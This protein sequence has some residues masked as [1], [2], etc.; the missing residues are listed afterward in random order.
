VLFLGLDLGAVSIKA[1]LLG[2]NGDADRVARL[3]GSAAVWHPQGLRFELAGQPAG[4][5]VSSYRRVKGRPLDAARDL[6]TSVFRSLPEGVVGGIRVTGSGGNLVSSALDFPEENEFRALAAATSAVAPDARTLFEIGGESSKMLLFEPDPASGDLAIVDY[7]TNGDCAAGT[8]SFLDQQAGRLRYDIEDVG[9][10]AGESERGAKIAGRCSVFAKSDMIHAQQKGYLPPEVLRGLC[11][12]V[13]RNF[14]AAVTK[15]KKPHPPVL[16]VGGVAANEMVASGLRQVFE[17]GEDLLRVPTHHAAHAAIGCAIREAVTDDHRPFSLADLQRIAPESAAIPRSRRLSMSKVVSLRDRLRPFVLPENGHPVEVTLGIDIGS[18]STNV[19]LLDSEGRVVRE[20]YTR[21]QARP[22]EVVTAALAELRDEVGDR[23]VVRAAGTTG[24]G[25]ELIGE[26]VGADTI[27]DEITAHKTGATF[28]A[29]TMLDGEVNTIFE[30]GGQDSKFIRI[31]DGVVV[32]FA[33]NEA[34][35]A[36]TGSFLEERAEELGVCIKGEFA[37]RALASAT[38]VRLGER[39]TVFM[40][41]DVNAYQQRGAPTDDLLAGLALSVATNYINRVVRDRKIDG[42]IFFQGGTAYNDAVAAAFAEILDRE[43]IVPP[44][45][46]VVGAVGAA[47][48]AW[49][50]ARTHD[51][52]TRFRGWDLGQVD[53]RI[54][55]FTCQGCENRCDMQ[56]FRVEGEKTYWGDQCG[57]RYRRRSK[58]EQRPV[59]DDLVKQRREWLV[60][61]HE[62]G[63]GRRGTVAFPRAL[64]F[65]DRFPYWSAFF[66]ELGFGVEIS[67]ET[68][69]AIAHE[70]VE[71]TVAEPCFPI[72]IAHGHVQAALAIEEADFVF[73]PNYVNAEAENDEIQSFFCPWAMT[74]PHVICSAATFEAEAN[75]IVRPLVR[76]RGGRQALAG[77]LHQSLRPYGVRRGEIERALGA[78]ETALEQFR[79]RIRDAGSRAVATLKESGEPAVLLVGRP[80]NLFDPVVNLDVPRKLRDFYGVNVLPL[81]FLAVDDQAIEEI[82]ANMFWSYGRKILAACREAARHTDLHLIYIT[83]FKCGPDSYIKHFVRDAFGRAFLTLQFDGHANDAG[84][85]TRVEAYLD[86]QGFLRRWKATAPGGEEAD[87][88]APAVTLIPPPW[89]A[90]SSFADEGGESGGEAERVAGDAADETGGHS[91]RR[92]RPESEPLPSPHPEVEVQ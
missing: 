65:Y 33:M 37:S 85:L 60:E 29:R 23:V 9:R 12:T 52:G 84:M 76:F 15:G 54:R 87:S 57:D 24:S 26:L 38:P 28:I 22:V 36:G 6:L 56:E 75:R 40:E 1:A 30:I 16:L 44:Y 51:G 64:Y 82:N 42:T 35:A 4:I 79:R 2:I 66:R 46:G 74:L 50:K 59:I 19:V 34:C 92:P 62:L 58:V 45:N 83:N 63:T 88:R 21:T 14:N 71:A 49:E 68:N 27:N 8:G 69:R 53:Y 86:S 13:A 41:R 80:Y 77:P 31:E 89:A 20:I 90:G 91:V 55:E 32:D 39:C 5:A 72:Q 11:E 73:I 25:R 78:G 81:E 70:G 61:G 3:A 43:I 17:L 48:L 7:Q 67:P 47:L 10:V 18:V